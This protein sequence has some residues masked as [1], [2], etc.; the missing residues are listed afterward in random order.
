MACLIGSGITT[1]SRE[2]G[3]SR[4]QDTC[5]Y[6]AVGRS[7][8]EQASSAVYVGKEA[9]A[10]RATAKLPGPAAAL[11]D[12]IDPMTRDDRASPLRPTC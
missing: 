11:K 5:R 8:R 1:A 6:L 10:K 12:L 4:P 9:V 7:R 2:T 3:V